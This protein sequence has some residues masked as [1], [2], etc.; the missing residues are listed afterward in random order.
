MSDD[1]FK[2]KSETGYQI[3]FGVKYRLFLI[4]NTNFNPFNFIDFAETNIRSI[5]GV[6]RLKAVEKYDDGT[7]FF[8]FSVAKDCN[9]ELL[10]EEIKNQFNQYFFKD[11]DKH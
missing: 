11:G 3:S 9:Y 7:G 4:M 10:F 5:T 6:E 1:H 2:L 8:I